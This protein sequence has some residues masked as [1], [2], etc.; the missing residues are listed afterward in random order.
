MNYLNISLELSHN[1]EVFRSLL[2]GVEKEQYLWRP[3][4]EKWCLLEVVCH[5]Y[6]EECEDFR[7]RVQHVLLTPEDPMPPIDP[8][9]WVVSRKYM[10]KDFDN[11][12]HGFLVE[13]GRSVNFLTGLIAPMWYNTHIHPQLGSVTASMFL[14]NWLAHDYL[15]IRQINELKYLYFQQKTEEPLTYAGSW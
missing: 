14:S 15:H 4:P 9:G 8:Q 3:S 6:D 12:L 10:E 1:K 11:E 2:H 5:L 13:R 7:A